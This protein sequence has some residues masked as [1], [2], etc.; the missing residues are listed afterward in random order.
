IKFSTFK[1]KKRPQLRTGSVFMK[2]KTTKLI[3]VCMVAMMGPFIIGCDSGSNESEGGGFTP[4]NANQITL[5]DKQLFIP[6]NGTKKLTVTPTGITVAWSSSDESVATVGADGTVTGNKVGTATITATSGD[7]SATCNVTVAET[8]LTNPGDLEEPSGS[9]VDITLNYKECILTLKQ[10]L[11]LEVK[12]AGTKVTW[13]SGNE[14]VAT[15]SENGRVSIKRNVGINTAGQTRKVEIIAT[16][17]DGNKEAKCVITVCSHKYNQ[18]QSFDPQCLYCDF[19]NPAISKDE[20]AAQD[21]P[22]NITSNGFINRCNLPYWDR[23]EKLEIPEGVI[24]IGQNAFANNYEDVLSDFKSVTIPSSMLTIYENA[25]TDCEKLK[26][27]YYNG[28]KEEW[29]D[30]RIQRDTSNPKGPVNEKMGLPDDTIIHGYETD[31]ITPTTWKIGE[32]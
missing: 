8:V 32:K 9:G 7:K 27:V 28:T 26:D 18:I 1:Q 19:K 6:L 22:F 21:N 31:G 29:D 3:A 30:I 11:Q 10:T 4:D 14:N 5:S 15:V 2:I 25:F 20:I 16:T 24:G 23:V 13:S 17:K 12:P